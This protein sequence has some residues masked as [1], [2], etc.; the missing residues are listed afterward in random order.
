MLS[1][2]LL[3]T[4]VPS[5]FGNQSRLLSTRVLRKFGNQLQMLKMNDNDSINDFYGKI[6]GIVAKFKN[7]GSTLKEEVIVRK[8]LE[9]VP[10][11]VNIPRLTNLWC[12]PCDH[13]ELL[14][15][16]PEV[17]ENKTENRKHEA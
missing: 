16:L 8:F 15:P 17:L 1:C 5:K 2:R 14:P 3:T 4:R 6:S 7:F 13:P 9:S 10:R 12:V 11:K